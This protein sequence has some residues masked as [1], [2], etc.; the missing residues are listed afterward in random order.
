MEPA[1]PAPAVEDQTVDPALPNASKLKTFDTPPEYVAKNPIAGLKHIAAA[2]LGDPLNGPLANS[3]YEPSAEQFMR[4]QGPLLQARGVQPGTEAFGE[5]FNE[6]KDRKWTQAYKAAEAEDRPLTRMEFIDRHGLGWDRLKDTL[7]NGFD[8]AGAFAKGLVAGRTLQ[9]SKVVGALSDAA[10][11]REDV[12]TDAAQAERHPFASLAGEVKGAASGPLAEITKGATPFSQSASLGARVGGAAIGG[13]VAGEADNLSRAVA[14]G[15]SD[16][17]HGEGLG[18]AKD[19][20]TSHLLG[21]G[22]L[23]GGLGAAG[24]LVAEGANAFQR[25]ALADAPELGQLRRGGGDTDIIHGVRPGQE[26]ADN[27]EAAR[28]PMPGE[29]KASPGATATEVATNKVRAPLAQAHT[30]LNQQTFERLGAEKQAAL[31]ANPALQKP[32]AAR[33]SAQAAVDWVKSKLQP[34]VSPGYL[35]GMQLKTRQVT[36]GAD[37]AEATKLVQQLYKPRLVT[38]V[39]AQN[40]AQASGGTVI[41]AEDAQKL[42]IDIG[43]L[44]HEPVPETG[45]PHDAPELSEGAI[46]IPKLLPKFPKAT[47]AGDVAP[48]VTP[49]E[50]AA[51]QR[52]TWG[53]RQPGDADVVNG[54]LDRAPSTPLPHVY[55]GIAMKPEQAH[56]M[57]ASGSFSTGDTPASVSSDPTVARSFA[58]RNRNAGDVGITLKLEGASARN[59]TPLAHEQVGGAEQELLLPAGKRFEIVSKHPDPANPGDWIVVAKE[60]TPEAHAGST[61]EDIFGTPAEKPTSSPVDRLKPRPGRAFKTPVGE[62]GSEWFD[63]QKAAETVALHSGNYEVNDPFAAQRSRSPAS[64]NADTPT[65]PGGAPSVASPSIRPSMPPP[66]LRA[67]PTPAA[68]QAQAAGLPPAHLKVVLEPR[69]YDAAKFEEILGDIDRK[70]GYERANGKVDPQWEKL[71]QAIRED[72][73]QFGPGWTDLI[74]KHHD[75]LNSLEQRSFH[76]GMA[77]DK[78]YPEMQGGAQARL[79]GKLKAFPGDSDSQKALREIAASAPPEVRRDLE[80]LGATNAYQQLKGS[81]KLK[82]SETFGGGGLAGRLTGVGGFLKPRADA[83]ARGLSAGPTGG[84]T[85]TPRLAAYLRSAEPGPG[86]LPGVPAMGGGALGLKAAV[87]YDALTPKQQALLGQ[88][89]DKF[90]KPAEAAGAAP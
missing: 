86:W 64:P 74:A 45:I 7:A 85:V 88:L 72:R 87:A 38:T 54:Y 65:M 35:P 36:P 71:A 9:G 63:K 24:Q 68:A 3:Y 62:P 41:S 25:S 10:T 58:A 19:Q 34:E 33:N 37:T 47:A 56:E 52:Y 30:D 14:S 57:M 89:I 82:T 20:F 59:I 76:A 69:E 26:V 4:E 75:E 43:Q 15:A 18:S 46:S 50:A 28:E 6:Y 67:T 78:A 27:I 84:V 8:T 42:G 29:A 61:A 22:L 16:L 80:V 66:E 49:E 81:A 5:A 79:Q 83:L 12:A 1:A 2:T 40:A 48:D 13:A 51:I 21:S 53:K 17:G 73:K 60:A 23:G 77:E 32:V 70:A 39:E 55:R 44:A 11:G 31:A 90:R